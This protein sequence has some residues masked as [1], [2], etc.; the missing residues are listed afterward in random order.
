MELPAFDFSV[1]S[2]YKTL[3]W[4]NFRNSSINRL[5]VRWKKKEKHIQRLVFHTFHNSAKFTN[6]ESSHKIQKDQT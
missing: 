4:V 1:R 6:S 5:D 2:D 3:R